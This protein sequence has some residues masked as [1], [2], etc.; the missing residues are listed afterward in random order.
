MAAWR[1]T[2]ATLHLWTQIVGKIRLS[3]APWR[4]H[5]WHTTLYL[6]PRG[7]TT[8]LIPYREGTFQIDFDFL[9]HH[10][11]IRAS[12]GGAADIPLR[13]QAVAEFHDELFGA[14]ARLGIEVKIH[15]MPN[16][17]ENPIPF[18]RDR[19][20]ASYDPEYANRLLQV[21]IQTER[22]FTRFQCRFV[23]KCSPVPVSYTHLTLPTSS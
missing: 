14:L 7:L 6:T 16:E 19:V 18:R 3:Q 5:S 9:D 11:R 8:S 4:N 21:L 12:D 10:L 22:V 17:I 23:G 15:G 2:Y 1:D 20:H 13:P